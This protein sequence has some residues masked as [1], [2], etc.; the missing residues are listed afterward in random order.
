MVEFERKL[1]SFAGCAASRRRQWMPGQL[2]SARKRLSHV[3]ALVL[4]IGSLFAGAVSA[5][6]QQ[7]VDILAPQAQVGDAKRLALVMGNSAYH[8][9]AALKNTI[10]DA[11]G[12][13]AK[14]Q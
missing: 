9:F 11:I 2:N 10:N 7:R 14:L 3:V 5:V 4:L 8:N 1:P 6:A 12:V 13:A